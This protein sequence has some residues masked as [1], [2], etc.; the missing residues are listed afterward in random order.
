VCLQQALEHLVV[1][2]MTT[3]RRLRR[4][5]EGMEGAAGM[6]WW[7]VATDLPGGC[8]KGWDAAAS[9]HAWCCISFAACKEGSILPVFVTDI[10]G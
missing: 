8:L 1:G 3:D 6:E 4:V 10:I 9:Q 5:P 7:W 2:A